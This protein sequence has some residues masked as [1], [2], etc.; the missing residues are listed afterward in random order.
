[1][2][3]GIRGFRAEYSRVSSD[4]SAINFSASRGVNPRIV[5]ADTNPH[6]SPRKDYARQAGYRRFQERRRRSR[7][8]GEKGAIAH[9]C[10]NQRRKMNRSAFSRP[11]GTPVGTR[12]RNSRICK[13]LAPRISPFAWY[14]VSRWKQVTEIP[15]RDTQ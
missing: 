8:L 1:M 9:A 5:N 3:G 13:T 10:V 14:H 6:S 15:R 2:F 7:L 4:P 11:F 12:S